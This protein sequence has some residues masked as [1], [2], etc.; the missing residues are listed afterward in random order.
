[1]LSRQASNRCL[2]PLGLRVHFATLLRPSDFRQPP[3]EFL[4]Q[5]V[6]LTVLEVVV[7]LLEFEQAGAYVC[8]YEQN[9][10]AC[11]LERSAIV[12]IQDDFLGQ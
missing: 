2:D 10:R 9:R 5:N 7:I 4:R 8:R 12:P 6:S 3:P 11:E 1:M